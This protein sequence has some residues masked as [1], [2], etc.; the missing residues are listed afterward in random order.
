MAQLVIES[1]TL[2]LAGLATLAAVVVAA[3]IGYNLGYG[4]GAGDQQTLSPTSTTNQPAIP[5][6]PPSASAPNTPPMTK[7]PLAGEP[8]VEIAGKTVLSGTLQTPTATG[9]T[10]EVSSEVYSTA[11]RRLVP[12]TTTYQVLVN[13]STKFI[14]QVSVVAIPNE[15]ALPK[16]TTTNKPLT[17]SGLKEGQAVT[18]TTNDPATA[19]TLTAL[20]VRVVSV[21]RN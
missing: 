17:A 14:E 20:E 16:V 19:K 9:F 5:I 8:V 2:G 3:T 21:V 4:S 6:T 11:T 15:G 13:K 12:K 10:L 18:V 1:R 7:L